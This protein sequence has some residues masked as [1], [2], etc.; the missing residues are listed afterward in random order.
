MIEVDERGFL[1]VDGVPVGRCVHRPDGPCLEFVDKDKR[2]SAKRGSDK[3]E[4]RLSDLNR[5]V[6]GEEREKGDHLF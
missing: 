2:R 3:V 1:K 5:V 6:K 4:V